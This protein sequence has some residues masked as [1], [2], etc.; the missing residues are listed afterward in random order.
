VSDLIYEKRDGIAY[1]TM[2]RPE[3]RNALSPEMMVRLAEA[4]IDF[5]DDGAMRVAIL[6]GA[7]D[8][9]FSAGADLARLIPLLSR[10]RAPEDEWDRRLLG[11]SS[12]LQTGLLRNFE[13]YK[14]VISAI[15]GFALAGGTEIALATDLRLA[16]PQAELGLTEVKRGLIPAGGSLVR[17][18]RQIP[19]CKTMEIL[20]IGDSIPAG[21]AHRIGLINEVVPGDRL[22]A[23]AEEIAHKIAENGPLA[24]TKCKEAVIRGSGLPLAEA[25]EVENGCAREVMR[26]HDAVEGPRAF[27]EKRKPSFTGR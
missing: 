27:M 8:R 13:L 15:N 9:A 18:P 7:G 17:L 19:Y 10:A 1:L 22:L 2:N 3:R 14:P 20:L 6:T 12:L 4:W 25:F 26:S 24:V 16:V 21:E 23:R 5:R 11:D